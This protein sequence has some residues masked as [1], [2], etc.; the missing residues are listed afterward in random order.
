MHCKFINTCRCDIDIGS[1]ED[2][3]CGQSVGGP[4]KYINDKELTVVF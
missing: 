3:G 1:I 4:R 2:I